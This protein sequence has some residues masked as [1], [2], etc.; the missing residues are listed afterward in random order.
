[1][2]W[3]QSHATRSSSESDRAQHVALSAR[4]ALRADGAGV[5]VT[6]TAVVVVVGGV[7]MRV[8]DHEEYSNIW[9]GMWWRPPSPPGQGFGLPAYRGARREG[10]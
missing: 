9:V 2:T 10:T 3:S 7:L 6:A 8:L 5:I 1:M 4:A